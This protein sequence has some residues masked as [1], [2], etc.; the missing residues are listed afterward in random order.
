MHITSIKVYN[1]YIYRPFDVPVICKIFKKYKFFYARVNLY[2]K[3]RYHCYN[4][5]L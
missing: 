5:N 2:F 4:Y 1:K 3:K